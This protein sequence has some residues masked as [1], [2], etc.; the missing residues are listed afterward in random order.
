VD[1]LTLR[2]VRIDGTFESWRRAARGLLQS[3]HPPDAVQFIADGESQSQLGGFE[4]GNRP[5]GAGSAA[6]IPRAFIDLA[7]SA[8]HHRDADRW[9][10]LYR[11][12]YRLT[13]GERAALEDE[14][15]R[16]VNR[17]RAMR[18]QVSRDIHKMHA[19]VRFREVTD[20]KGERFV[21]WHRPD[22]YITRLAAP[23][24]VER[25]RVMRWSILTPDD[26]AHW[27]G[28]TL[29]FGAGCPQ[30]D[31]PPEDRLEDLWRTYYASMFNPARANERA[32]VRELPRRHWATLPEAQLIPSLLAGATER[33][34]G[35]IAQPAAKPSARPFIP[36]DASLPELASAASVC[37]GCALFQDATQVVFGLGPATAAIML[38][39][40]QPGDEEDLQGAPF[41]GPAGRMLD[42]V[43][44]E[45]GLIRNDLY[46]TNAVKHF[47]FRREGKRRIHEKPRI[48]D[49]RACRPWLETEIER[50]NPRVIVCMGAT[51]AQSLLGPTVRIQRDRGLV[52]NSSWAPHTIV[53]YHPSAVLR[54]DD[55]AHAEEIRRWLLQDLQLAQHLSATADTMPQE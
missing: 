25:F 1:G 50:I 10:L 47:T 36:A 52:A 54:A 42:E 41:V 27:D 38:I 29:T 9:S 22:H 21:A 32:M 12:A 44:V 37:R 3:H 23:F 8:A 48:G 39:G 46:V 18:K 53:T 43:I 15:D 40:E 45:A 20:E 19:F 16:D 35:M 4:F 6:S 5:A 31:A 26:S 7:R 55:P 28:E 51:A 49:V 17:L 13:H 11:V 14:L 24:F 2:A 34:S 33:V 30:S